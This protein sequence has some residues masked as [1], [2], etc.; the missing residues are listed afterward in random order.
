M[1]AAAG[2]STAKASA[3]KEPK[4]LIRKDLLQ[5]QRGAVGLP[6]RN[7]FSP[8][9]SPRNSLQGDLGAA[10]KPQPG[11]GDEQN[12]AHGEEAQAPPAMTINLRYIGFVESPRKRIGLIILEGQTMAVVEGDVISEGVRI[13]KVTAQEIEIIMPDSTTRKFSLEGE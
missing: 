11:L 6:K 4:S 7:I 13:G 12:E 9:S 2:Q 10:Q 3:G 5:V 8:Q 1:E